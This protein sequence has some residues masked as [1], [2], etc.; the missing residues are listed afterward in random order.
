M[1]K[2]SLQRSRR[3]FLRR[4]QPFVFNT[5][6][7]LSVLGVLTLLMENRR[8]EVMPCDRMSQS[9]I[10]HLMAISPI[11]RRVTWSRGGFVKV[12]ESKNGG[13]KNTG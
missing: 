7:C 4:H 2:K 3:G 12:K 8:I 10:C 13:K 6:E 1:D 11:K 9:G 5:I